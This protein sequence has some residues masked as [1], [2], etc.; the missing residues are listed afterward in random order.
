MQSKFEAKLHLLQNMKQ[1]YS[2]HHQQTVVTNLLK[3]KFK[4]YKT[5]SYQKEIEVPHLKKVTIRVYLLHRVTQKAR[6]SLSTKRV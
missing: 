5:I 3:K 1:S 4:S 6:S 2:I